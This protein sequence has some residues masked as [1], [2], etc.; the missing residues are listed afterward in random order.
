MVAMLKE[1]MIII[2]ASI[3]SLDFGMIKKTQIQL[4]VE[5]IKV[6]I[7]VLLVIL[8]VNNAMVLSI[9]VSQQQIAKKNIAILMVVIILMKTISELALMNQI[10]KNGK[11]F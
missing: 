11:I 7:I 6:F 2:V 10:K 5:K 4:V 1:L 3:V 8:L 9:I